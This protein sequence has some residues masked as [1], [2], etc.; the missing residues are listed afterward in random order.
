MGNSSPKDYSSPET[1][2]EEMDRFDRA[3]NLGLS[4][5]K[6]LI[7]L[8]SG[9][10]IAVLTFLGSASAQTQFSLGLTQIKISLSLF[11]TSML[12]IILGMVISY[13]YYATPP[14]EGYSNFWN[15][16][17]VKFNVTMVMLALL[18][19]IMGVSIII[20]GAEVSAS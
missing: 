19:F 3:D 16:H 10:I 4:T 18:T 13:S 17:I 9:A 1:K 5:A 11:L 8:N 12:A 7:T 20:C 14:N 2:S 15:K 6:V